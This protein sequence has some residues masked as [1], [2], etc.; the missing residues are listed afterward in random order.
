MRDLEASNRR[1]TE[2]LQSLATGQGV[3]P[4][5]LEGVKLMRSDHSLPRAPVL[6][7]P[8]IFIVGQGRKRGYLGS[9]IYTYDPHNYLVLSAPM[10]FE[11]ET[12]AGPHGPFLA[13]SISIDLTVLSELLMKLDSRPSPEAASAHAMCSVPLDLA[14]SEAGVRLLESLQSPTDARIL[15][16]QI[17]RE[18]TYRVLCG[19]RGDS[20]RALIALNGRV[21]QIQRALDR[22]HTGYAQPLDISTLAGDAGMSLSAFHHHF[23]AVTALSPLQ[24]LKTIRLHKARMLMVQEGLGAGIAA[25]R[26]GYESTSQFSREFKRFFGATPSD[27][28]AR[29][30]ALLGLEA[31]TGIRMD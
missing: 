20:L 16:P 29:M 31:S 26:V 3:R 18:I 17:M 27:E 9:Q 21:R 8:G 6:Y 2:L 24:Y 12:E 28:A 4:S 15:G 1:M 25:G 23:K 14:L 10:P 7:E 30:R 19:E 22:M 5:I 11:C 13:V